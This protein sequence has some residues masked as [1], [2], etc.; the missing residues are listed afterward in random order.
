MKN[1][2]KLPF[3]FGDTTWAINL[4]L[5]SSKTNMIGDTKYNI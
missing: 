1:N 3:T 2:A 5:V 4:Q